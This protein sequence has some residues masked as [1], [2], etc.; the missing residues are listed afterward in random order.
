MSRSLELTYAPTHRTLESAV[1][2]EKMIERLRMRSR[3][4]WEDERKLE[5][6]VTPRVIAHHDGAVTIQYHTLTLAPDSGAPLSEVLCGLWFPEPELAKRSYEK[7]QGRAVLFD[8]LQL[9]LPV[10]PCDPSLPAL[11]K[12]QRFEPD[13]EI[14]GE[15]YRYLLRLADGGEFLIRK[16]V[17]YR[18][19]KRCVLEGLYRP[20]DGPGRPAY[21]K[22]VRPKKLAEMKLAQ[23]QI[24]AWL[25]STPHQYRFRAPEIL[26]D[27]L[28]AGV[29]ISEAV[30]SPLLYNLLS[31]PRFPVASHAAGSVLRALHNTPLESET[32]RSLTVEV[33]E[34]KKRIEALER[35]MPELGRRLQE[36]LAELCGRI[37]AE[38]DEAS[39]ISHGDYY[40]KQVMYQEGSVCVI[41]VDRVE[42]ADPA[43]DVGNF[44]AH[45]ALRGIQL[46]GAPGIFQDA[47]QEF[48]R[49][50]EAV[51]DSFRQRIA[52]WRCMSLLRLVGVYAVRPGWRAIVPSI[53]E[54]A[55]MY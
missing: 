9:V 38:I 4:I 45:L 15:S 23:S 22:C 24:G 53:F 36:S 39:L 30:T 28:D 35:I 43:L 41:D 51:S 3:E 26:F 55:E 47:E 37:P 48:M 14:Q 12:L 7:L 34:S 18:F 8:D 40:D 19:G 52:W 33:E 44:L 29:I 5:K 54:L 16:V 21:C 50:Y 31:E 46:H 27:D 32:V 11:M 20:V 2:A 6:V 42:K 10:F 49:G 17:A 13:R 25:K 1:D